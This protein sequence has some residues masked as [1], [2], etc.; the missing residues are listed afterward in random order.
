MRLVP[1]TY[2]N[3]GK[4]FNDGRPVTLLHIENP[5]DFDA[6]LNNITRT[7]YY[8]KE[9]FEHNIGH[10]EKQIKVDSLYLSAITEF[11]RPRQVLDIGC[12][13]GEVLLLLNLRGVKNSYGVDLSHT[14]LETLWSPLKGKV[15]CGDFQKVCQGYA[16]EKRLFDI[17]LA[18]DI[19]EHLHPLKLQE[20]ISSM[21]NIAT[22]DA[23]FFFIIPA[24]GTDRIFGEVF[25]LEFEEN[26]CD[27]E[28]GRPFKYLVAE[29]HDP[30]IPA[31][32]HLIW[33]PSTWW[34]D[35]FKLAG[36]HRVE[37]LET[38]IHCNF[39]D[40]LWFAQKSFFIFRTDTPY[41]K[42]RVNVL[43]KKPLNEFHTCRLLIEHYKALSSFGS[44]IGQTKILINANN[45]IIDEI[46]YIYYQMCNKVFQQ[47]ESKYKH[48][49]GKGLI[50]RLGQ[51]MILP[52]IRRS[53]HILH[54]F[55]LG[56][57]IPMKEETATSKSE[58]PAEMS[59][60]NFNR[61]G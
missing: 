57:K 23:L 12:G 6:I 38:N 16:R 37:A 45:K 14:V 32:G 13:H 58:K 4:R 22:P 55:L 35:Q 49:F 25:P 44:S 56:V 29:V 36:L 7:N 24:F 48:F 42:K 60:T 19:W 50:Y 1:S 59:S 41:S 34:E 54:R 33:A 51:L 17:I 53:W 9:Y 26:R 5:D 15:E 18:F 40:Y 2:L 8:G 61:K 52:A 43:L 3:N 27:L 47:I 39:D 11:L 28:A 31:S 10:S 30:P 20:Y 46:N 21:L